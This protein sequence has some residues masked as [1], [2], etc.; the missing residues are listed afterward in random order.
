MIDLSFVKLNSSKYK[1]M[2]DTGLTNEINIDDQNTAVN[3]SVST[4]F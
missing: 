3:I 4:I 1:R 2:Y